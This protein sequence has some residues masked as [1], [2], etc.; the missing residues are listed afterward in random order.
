MHHWPPAPHARPLR[1]C[2]ARRPRPPPPRAP[3][4]P[5]APASPSTPASRP[6]RARDDHGPHQAPPRA[7]PAA[8]PERRAP[9][10]RRCLHVAHVLPH[11][12][13]PGVEC[14][15][16]ARERVPYRVGRRLKP[17]RA[18]HG[19]DL[20]PRRAPDR[21]R[22]AHAPP[23]ARRI[24]ARRAS[25]TRPASHPHDESHPTR[26]QSHSGSGQSRDARTNSAV[27]W[28]ASPSKIDSLMV[29]SPVSQP[30]P[31]QPLGA[32]CRSRTGVA[33][34]G[35]ARQKQRTGVESR[36]GSAPSSSPWHVS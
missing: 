16:T 8:M 1:L 3:P 36:T 33:S 18:R 7:R 29:V 12:P 35:D 20:G 31:P 23:R 34:R 22:A 11:L 28:S 13:A 6:H 24:A 21:L 9:L 32:P 26:R 5:P 19:Q 27:A 17:H 25:F 30:R 15:G 14:D 4:Q 10:T 2:R